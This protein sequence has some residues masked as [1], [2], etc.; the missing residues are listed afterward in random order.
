MVKEIKLTYRLK[1]PILATGA[2]LKGSFALAKGKKIFLLDG[3]GDLGDLDNFLNYQRLIEKNKRTLRISPDVIACDLHPGYF[4]TKVAERLHELYC[5]RYPL[6]RIQHHEAHVASC[7]ADNRVNFGVIGVA[8]DGTGYGPDGNIWGGEFFVS[9]GNGFERVAHLDYVAMPGSEMAIKE[10]WRMATSYLY[11]AFASQFLKLKLEFLKI[12]GLKKLSLVRNMIDKGIN[13]PLTSS[14]GRLF[15]AVSSLILLKEKVEREAEAAIE[16][17]ALASKECEE[18]Y[19]FSMRSKGKI[20]IIDTNSIIKGIT[21]GL[22]DKSPKGV[23]SAKFHNTIARMITSVSMRLRDR[24]NIGV[25]ALSGGVFQNR[26][27][28]RRTIDY[29][30][31]KELKVLTHTVV[32]TGDA[33]IPLGQIRIANAKLKCN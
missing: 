13:A 20:T 12:V 21:K 31:E 18:S 8:F 7:T 23:I 28:L 2:D 25:V 30:K 27:L 10:P 14:A 24:Y 3:L 33:G 19:P 11:R 5:V 6:M 29:L 22:I 4:S 9:L 26:F 15:D 17:E 16:L 1:R 32:P